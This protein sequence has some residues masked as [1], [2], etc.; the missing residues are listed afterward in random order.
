MRLLTA[1]IATL[2]ILFGLSQ[3]AVT[4]SIKGTPTPCGLSIV[5]NQLLL[6]AAFKAPRLRADKV[7]IIYLGHSTF[8]IE[9]PSGTRAAT[10][11]NGFNVIP[12]R[13]PHIVTMNNSHGTH[14]ADHVDPAIKFVLRGWN[15]TGGIA[16]H[17]IMHRDMRVYNLPTNIYGDASNATNG[18]SVFVFEAAGICVAH[19]GHLHHALSEEQVKRI[20]RID[21]L[22]VPIDGTVTLSHE[23]AFNIINQIKPRIIMPMH[24][25]FGG[26][27]AF[28]EQARSRF[29]IRRH[30][31]A[32]I[33]IGRTDL[34]E[35]TEILFLGNDS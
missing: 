23:E 8:Q 19:L 31:N 15:P 10:D 28:V 35:K 9:T 16:R 12:N 13:L 17:H 4:Q 1:I 32:Y 26:P 25:S 18:N 22:F 20:G 14:Y 6:R 33:D 34:P 5:Q 29:P 7:R 30:K 11:F 2:G 27:F 3:P 24:F 21:I